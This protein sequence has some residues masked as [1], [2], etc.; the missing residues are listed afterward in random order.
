MRHSVKT[1]RLGRFSSLRKATLRS[2]ATSIL[3]HQRIITTKAKAKSARPLIDKMITLG[4]KGNLSARRRA[5][6][7]LC[8]HKLV[9]LLFDQIAPKFA[10]INGGYTRIMPY[11]FQRGD[12]AHLV[13]FELTQ[14]Y[15]EE[16]PKK[17]KE[18]K[19]KKVPLA[20]KQEAPEKPIEAEV[21]EEKEVPK[22]ITPHAHPKEEKS[23]KPETKKPKGFFGG[24][25][26]LFK[27]ERDSL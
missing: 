7:L 2:I 5:F 20:K 1:D 3:I 10:S 25:K 22:A 12:N 8:D 9:K 11:R 4:K 16:K 23:K 21:K 27:K 15:K 24:F 19:E 26:G 14:T 17:V 18:E 6:S 13:I